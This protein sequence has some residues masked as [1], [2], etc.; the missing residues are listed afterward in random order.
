MGVCTGTCRTG[1]ECRCTL[2]GARSRKSRNL[3]PE[4]RKYQWLAF[5]ELGGTIIIFSVR[6]K[7]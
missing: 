4:K 1:S 2:A 7:N 6:R 5:T 3:S